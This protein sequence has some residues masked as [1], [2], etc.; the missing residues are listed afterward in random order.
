LRTNRNFQKSS[1]RTICIA[2]ANASCIAEKRS[3]DCV[4]FQGHNLAHDRST[5]WFEFD[6]F[7]GHDLAKSIDSGDS[8]ADFNDLS[9]IADFQRAAELNSP[10][11]KA[12]K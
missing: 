1:S 9:D 10:S 4:R 2:F 5:L 8:V 3:A 12:G 7:A 11:E 6:Q